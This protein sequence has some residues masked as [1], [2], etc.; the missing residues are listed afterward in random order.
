MA[1]AGLGARASD[2]GSHVFLSTDPGLAAYS[3]D[4]PGKGSCAFD[5][6]GAGRAAGLGALC[7]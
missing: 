6:F 4:S 3:P 2:S 5:V 7:K 1:E